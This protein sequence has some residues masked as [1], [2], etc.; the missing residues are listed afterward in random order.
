MGM[1]CLSLM[2][3]GWCLMRRRRKAGKGRGR[4]KRRRG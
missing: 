4:R 1:R 3:M 2:L